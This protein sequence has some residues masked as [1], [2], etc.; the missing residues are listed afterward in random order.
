MPMSEIFCISFRDPD[1]PSLLRTIPDPPRQLYGRGNREL[2][3]ASSLCAIVGSRTPT[4]YGLS[5]ATDIVRTCVQRAVVTVSGLAFGID[6]R[7]HRATVEENG[8]TIAIVGSSVDNASIYPRSH[9]VLVDT[10]ISSG[11]LILSEHP[12]ETRAHK[13]SFPQRN[14]IIAGISQA[15][16]VV[17]ARAKS[18]SLITAYQALDYNRNV[19]AVPGSIYS[20]QSHGTLELIQRGAIPWLHSNSFDD[21]FPSAPPP[22]QAQHSPEAVRILEHCAEPTS[23]DELVAITHLPVSTLYAHIGTLLIHEHLITTPDGRY[24]ARSLS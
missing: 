19:F 22:I 15:T 23:I 13:G 16:C 5:V 7:V 14:R 11:G 6:A 21:Y 24:L 17:E 20:A 4:A 1:Y 10:I 8:A 9:V 18:G 12:P 3:T 2:L